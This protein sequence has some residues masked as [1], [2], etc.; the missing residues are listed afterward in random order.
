MLFS[1]N[2]ELTKSL[3]L[4]RRKVGSGDDNASDQQKNYILGAETCK[5]NRESKQYT[6]FFKLETPKD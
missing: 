4:K 3:I 1:Q 2:P 5:S 6:P